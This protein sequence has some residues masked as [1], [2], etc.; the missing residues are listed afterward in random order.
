LINRAT[1]TATLNKI[2]LGVKL[3]K[4]MVAA[5]TP[6]VKIS[7]KV[8]ILGFGW[9]TLYNYYAESGFLCLFRFTYLLIFN[10][11]I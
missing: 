1:D 11:K 4:K 5:I 8:T 7:K 2:D 3:L 10:V 6:K 9:K